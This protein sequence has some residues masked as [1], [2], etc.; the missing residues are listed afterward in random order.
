[1]KGKRLAS[2][3]SHV[4]KEE[5]EKA[6]DQLRGKVMPGD[7]IWVRLRGL[8]WWPAQVVNENAVSRSN[9]PG[10]R[11]EDEVLVRVYGTYNY[12]YVDPVKCRSEFENILKQNNGSYREIFQ[13]ALEQDLPSAKCGR[14]KGRGSKSKESA[15][16]V[17]SKT[18]K[19]NGELKKLKPKRPSAKWEAKCK[20]S[21]QNGVQKEPK[22]TSLSN[23]DD[24]KCRT[25][26]HSGVQKKHNPNSLSTDA[27]KEAKSKTV[28]DAGLQK[29]LVPNSPSARKEAKGKTPKRDVVQKKLE[30][31]DAK[32][33][34][35]TPT[36]DG[37]LQKKR[38][39][40][41]QCYEEASESKTLK[42]DGAQKK[43]KLNSPSTE[44]EAKRK[45]SKKDDMLK[46]LNSNS[47]CTATSS[48]RKT[49]EKISSR[50][51]H[52]LNARRMRV[53][54]SLGLTAP[55]GSPFDRNGH[56]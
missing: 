32:E 3:K 39:P 49:S 29:K 34:S 42:Q 52:I 33:Q 56:T 7:L 2:S 6:A 43:L 31:I 10:N 51:S 44:K 45:T 15:E 9:K 17:E 25:S 11:S 14:S 23:E 41:S 16:E 46:K 26:Q 5:E 22:P 36:Q 21:K 8:S 28:E 20:T 38:R 40:S 47:P 30:L 13:K 19:E 55:S 24:T 54:R 4:V 50:K 53:M 12:L 48:T 18:F 1:M 35:N 27:K 37:V